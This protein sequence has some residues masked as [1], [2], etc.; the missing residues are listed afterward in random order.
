[1]TSIDKLVKEI[2]EEPQFKTI[3]IGNFLD[4]FRRSSNEKRIR[5]IRREPKK[6]TNVTKEDYAYIAAMVEKLC[7]DNN[8]QPPKWVFKEEYFLKDPWFPEK[9]REFSRMRIVLMIE[10]PVEFK[11]RNLFV[12]RNA[13]TRA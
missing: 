1:M 8:I 12:S 6:Y 10:S 13:L 5:G 4:D 11:K 3:H 2:S 9:I 7:V